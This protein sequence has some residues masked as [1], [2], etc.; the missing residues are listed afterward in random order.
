MYRKVDK[1]PENWSVE[2]HGKPVIV[3][4][5]EYGGQSVVAIDDHT[6]IVPGR[7]LG[8]ADGNE[9]GKAPVDHVRRE[10]ELE[11][12]ALVVRQPVAF[13]RH[14]VRPDHAIRRLRGKQPIQ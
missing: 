2:R 14:A 3:L 13:T 10:V 4:E 12:A 9:A 5:D 7:M 6:R 8:R 11:P 1:T